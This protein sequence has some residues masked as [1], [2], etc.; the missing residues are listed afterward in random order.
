MLAGAWSSSS[1]P[2]AL[3]PDG[4]PAPAVAAARRS[5]TCTTVIKA[6]QVA[7]AMAARPRGAGRPAAV[8]KRSAVRAP[9]CPPVDAAGWWPWPGAARR[10]SS[11]SPCPAGRGLA[12]ACTASGVL[13]P[14]LEVDGIAVHPLLSRLVKRHGSLAYARPF[15]RSS[16]VAARRVH[17]HIYASAVAAAAGHRHRR[18]TGGDRAHRGA[19]AH[20]PGPRS[21]LADLPAGYAHRRRS[22]AIERL[23]RSAYR[24]PRRPGRVL[25][26]PPRRP[27]LICQLD[28]LVVSSH[29]DG[30]RSSCWRPRPP[31]CRSSPPP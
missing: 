28:M 20:G 25:R 22:T 16:A 18:P 21:E 8:A 13:A 7:A 6:N 27:A 30:S 26:L 5:P 11:S 4:H 12:V 31:G 17:A 1:R 3:V 19:V 29:S 9:P 24:V 2:L 14:A 23:L 10:S 15:A